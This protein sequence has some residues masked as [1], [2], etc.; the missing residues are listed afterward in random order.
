MDMNAV[1]RHLRDLWL[2]EK[3]GRIGTD[4]CAFLD[5][6]KQLVSCYATGSDNRR[7]PLWVVMR[8]LTDLRL[9]LRLTD[10]GVVITQRRGRGPAGPATRGADVV[11]AWTTED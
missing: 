6:R 8:L 10:G 3:P 11:V 9:E 4:L 1:F 5:T 7:P 2:A